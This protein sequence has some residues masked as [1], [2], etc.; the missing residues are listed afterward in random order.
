M[1]FQR[2]WHSV[3]PRPLQMKSYLGLTFPTPSPH[4]PCAVN[5]P[6]KC[7][8]TANNIWANI[9]PS[10]V[11]VPL[12]TPP[13]PTATLQTLGALQQDWPKNKDGSKRLPNRLFQKYTHSWCL[14]SKSC[15]ELKEKIH[16]TD[17][18]M[19]MKITVKFWHLR[20]KK[21]HPSG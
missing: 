6:L 19:K 2:H 17:A 7:I 8:Y 16:P 15:Q 10:L 5:Q 14:I 13:K 21:H 1:H 20:S 11:T 9:S 18:K 3:L 12:K 4:K